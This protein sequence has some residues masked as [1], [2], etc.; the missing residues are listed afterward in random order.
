MKLL[1]RSQLVETGVAGESREYK[2]M[3]S[4]Q[5]DAD[6]QADSFSRLISVARY[7]SADE[8]FCCQVEENLVLSQ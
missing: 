7:T 5:C 2:S 6:G 3:R 1:S 8:T 4:T